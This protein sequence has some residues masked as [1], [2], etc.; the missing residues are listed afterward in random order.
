VGF[1]LGV[2]ADDGQAYVTIPNAGIVQ[3]LSLQPGAL[4]SVIKV[5]GNPRRVG[6]SRLGRIGAITNLSGYLTFIR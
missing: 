4:S 5:G 6:F 1:G 3:V 2:T